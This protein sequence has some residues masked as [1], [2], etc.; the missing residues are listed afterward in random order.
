MSPPGLRHHWTRVH[1][2]ASPLRA[3]VNGLIV[4]DIHAAETDALPAAAVSALGDPGSAR[5]KALKD[6]AIEKLSTEERALARDDADR[7]NEKII[8][9]A[10]LQT[11]RTRR[12][13]TVAK[14]KGFADR[15]SAP[16]SDKGPS[17][18]T[19]GPA[20]EPV[21]QAGDNQ[22][23]LVI[24]PAKVETCQMGDSPPFL[25]SASHQ[26]RRRSRPHPPPRGAGWAGWS[27]H[28]VGG[29]HNNSRQK[30]A[31]PS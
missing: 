20:I 27:R 5:D 24:G 11:C 18:L 25:A 26:H 19:A 2:T 15:V 29:W 6:A 8:T 21:S 17:A 9:L 31:I 1:D 3:A 14:A 16:A 30:R 23:V 10:T 22:W 13:A 12:T 4:S 28:S 7:A